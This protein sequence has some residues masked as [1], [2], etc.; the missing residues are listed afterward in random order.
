MSK[1]KALK[2]KEFLAYWAELKPGQKI[3][4]RP[5]PYKHKGSTF[6]QDGIRITGSRQ[7]V[8]SVLSNL[9]QLLIHEGPLTRLQVNYRQATDRD[10]GRP[11]DSW[12]AY[13]QVHNR[14][15]EAQMVNL[16]ISAVSGKEVVVSS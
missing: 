10:T 13:I 12:T 5:V 6:D 1:P 14:G 7:F 2:K 16:F 9:Q 11:L 4:P 15:G 8:D 3:K